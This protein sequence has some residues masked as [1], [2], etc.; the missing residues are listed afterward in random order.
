[1]IDPT[2]NL[3]DLEALVKISHTLNRALD[4]RTALNS[5]LQQ[6]VQLMGLETGWIFIRQPAS[7]ERWAGRGY[8]LAAHYQLPPAL[9]LE[10]REAWD[11]GCN[12]QGLCLRGELN[13]AY[14]EVKCS[15]LEESTGER[16]GLT[17]HASTPL[18]SGTEILGILNVAARDWDCFD[19]RALALL[20]SVG[21]QMGVALERAQLHDMLSI[22]RAQEQ[23]TLLTL[24]EKLL[25]RSTIEGLEHFIV[26]ETCRLLESDA[27]ALLLPDPDDHEHLFFLAHTGWQTDP[28]LAKRRVSLD[29]QS[30]VGK[31]MITQKPFVAALSAEKP[32]TALDHWAVTESFKNVA[33]VPLLV[34]S[35]AVGVMVVH[36]RREQHFDDADL[37]FLQLLA[38]QAAIAME[39]W[40]LVN[41]ELE[42]ARTER[43][44]A[45]GR[46]VQRSMLPPAYPNIPGWQFSVAYKA[47]R[48]LG[49]D[50]YDFFPY[51]DR[52]ELWSI[53]IA[54]VS[55]KGVPAA[56]YMVLSRTTIRNTAQVDRSPAE[57]LQKTNQ[58]ILEDSQADMFLS[59]FYATLD[60][61]T[62]RLVYSNA[63]HNHPL[64][65]RSASSQLV[66]LS[67]HGMLLGIAESV[68]LENHQIEMMPGD[69]LILYTDGI[70][71]AVN[72][73]QEEFGSENLEKI[74]TEALLNNPVLDGEGMINIILEEVNLFTADQP[75]FDDETLFVVKRLE[76]RN[77]G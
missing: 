14:N 71:E 43:E 64:W 36:S 8:E 2:N 74:V 62:G 26:N 18:Q 31:A 27:C 69:M 11:K 68:Q 60:T 49:G 39:A 28:V 42:W 77:V 20:T 76:V 16:N 35:R 6:L 41:E 5:S 48:D 15:R 56:L 67:Q 17:V 50:F 25:K 30:W 58:Y 55:D 9:D 63:G 73:K 4:V 10:S 70:T 37:R 65:W 7:K 45:F 3:A 54:D 75:I 34:D 19:K 13:E 46:E 38:N 59:V 57:V 51:L 22:R 12:C 33:A 61:R 72:D 47:A 32:G 29:S 53:V 24:S 23:S 66:T 21:E 44:L 40:R 52:S 1:M